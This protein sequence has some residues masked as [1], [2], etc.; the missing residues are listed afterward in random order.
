MTLQQRIGTAINGVLRL[1]GLRLV[2]RPGDVEA[3]LEAFDSSLV[4]FGDGV[5]LRPFALVDAPSLRAAYDRPDIAEHALLGSQRTHPDTE[6]WLR[7]QADRRAA[8]HE[9]SFAVCETGRRDGPCVG[10]ISLHAVDWANRRAAVG[11][12]LLPA[13]RGRGLM[14]AS[15]DRVVRW[16]FD[17]IGLLRLETMAVSHNTASLAVAERC[18]FRREGLMRSWLAVGDERQDMVVLARLATDATAA[19]RSA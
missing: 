1:G 9:V 17:E 19:R 8:G 3:S 5:V 18:G 16:A 4:L 7:V 13:A 11:Y 12:W 6:R 2:R 14:T 15:L 10:Q